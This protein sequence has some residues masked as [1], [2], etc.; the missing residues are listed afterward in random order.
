MANSVK[1]PG[2]DTTVAID[3]N[4][5]SNRFVVARVGEVVG[6]AAAFGTESRI[7]EETYNA[8]SPLLSDVV[9]EP[10]DPAHDKT[11]DTTN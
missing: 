10:L 6:S 4:L 8:R 2:H 11:F 7:V 3:Y 5:R 1:S 9:K